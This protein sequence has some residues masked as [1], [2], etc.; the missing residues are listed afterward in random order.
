MK[1]LWMIDIKDM[2][3]IVIVRLMTGSVKH[4]DLIKFSEKMDNTFYVFK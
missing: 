2:K 3:L 4:S 1:K